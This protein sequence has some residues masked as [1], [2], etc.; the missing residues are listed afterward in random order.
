[1][2]M[3]GDGEETSHVNTLALARTQYNEV[4]SDTVFSNGILVRLVM[5]YDDDD[6]GTTDPLMPD[7]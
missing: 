7:L 4:H 3:I 5:K 2:M 6:G 1:M